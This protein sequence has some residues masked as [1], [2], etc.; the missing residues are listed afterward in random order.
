MPYHLLF[1]NK[2]VV[3]DD[4]KTEKEIYS[5]PTQSPINFQLI[6]VYNKR[7]RTKNQTFRSIGNNYWNMMGFI[8]KTL[9]KWST[10]T[11]FLIENKENCNIPFNM[12]LWVNPNAQRMRKFFLFLIIIII[13]RRSIVRE[14]EREW[15][16]KKNYEKSRTKTR[17]WETRKIY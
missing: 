11:G 15:E 8:L 5:K 1:F 10:P 16:R 12:R 14:K 7:R 2:Q 3:E 9:W 17:I 4:E 13:W 6:F